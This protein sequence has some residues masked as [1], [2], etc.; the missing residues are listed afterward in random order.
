MGFS[1]PDGKAPKIGKHIPDEE[2]A[3]KLTDEMTEDADGADDGCDVRE[4]LGL[5]DWPRQINMAVKVTGCTCN[6][7]EMF[8]S[9]STD[10]QAVTQDT[11]ASR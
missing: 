7:L 10:L 6:E 4:K 2:T 3:D 8:F 5:L 11:H 1:D 9:W